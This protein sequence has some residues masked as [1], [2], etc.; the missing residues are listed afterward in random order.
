[1]DTSFVP[2]IWND[3]VLLFTPLAAEGDTGKPASLDTLLQ[4]AILSLLFD[5]TVVVQS[6]S[7]EVPLTLQSS[8]DVRSAEEVE[9]GDEG[10]N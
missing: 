8:Y 5:R 2:E 7:S 10:F 1:V 3:G 4:L 9:S 6:V